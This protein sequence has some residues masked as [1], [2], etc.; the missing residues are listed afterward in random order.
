MYTVKLR[1]ISDRE[2]F[3]QQQE[4]SLNGVWSMFEASSKGPLEL[5][6]IAVVVR[7]T[8]QDIQEHEHAGVA[9]VMVSTRRGHLRR[10]VFVDPNHVICRPV[11]TG[12]MAGLAHTF[13]LQ[14]L[15]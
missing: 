15:V 10:T 14:T 2:S 9:K 7:I 1:T 5:P 4:A 13:L 8:V 12:S 3:A 6:V 11:L